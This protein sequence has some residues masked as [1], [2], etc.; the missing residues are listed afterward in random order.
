MRVFSKSAIATMWGRGDMRFVLESES[1]AEIARLSEALAQRD[2]LAHQYTSACK[3]IG[4]IATERDAAL[5]RIK[6]LEEALKT[7]AELS[8]DMPMRTLARAA[9]SHAQGG[10]DG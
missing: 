6:V 2:T 3:I 5:T 9:L 8:D 1:Q 7:V 4:K 10:C